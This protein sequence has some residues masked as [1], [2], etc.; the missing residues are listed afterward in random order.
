MIVN[1][2]F[3][4]MK[5]DYRMIKYLLEIRRRKHMNTNILIGE[6]IR[7]ERERLGLTQSKVA[8]KVGISIRQLSRIENGECDLV[9]Y[10][11]IGLSNE[12]HV[13][14]DYILKGCQ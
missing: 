14:T 4:Y 6:R 11:V 13:T 10:V 12:L 8:E 9:A 1:K 5:K 3:Y 2:L 7:I